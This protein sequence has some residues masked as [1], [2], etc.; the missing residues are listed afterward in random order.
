MVTIEERFREKFAASEDWHRRGRELFAGGITHQT[1]FTSPFA[2]YIEHGDGPFKFDVDGNELVDYV[3]GNGSLLMGH[4][5]SAVTD[6]V[7]AQATRGTHHGWRRLPTKSDTLRQSSVSC[8]TWRR[9][10]FT[11]SGTESTYLALRL[12]RAYTGKTKI[13][14]F[15]EHF[16]GWHDYVTPE[17]GQALGGVPRE[18]I[19]TV[20]VAPVDAAALDRILTE[21][22]DVAA[23]IVECQR[24]ALRHLPADESR[25]SS[26]HT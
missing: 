19:D 26:G 8:R 22:D 13:V 24:R 12:A 20:I 25:L 16:H 18:I 23:V 4:N 6:A 9:V 15:H 14:K 17:S 10:R 5:P 3:M 21:N 2:V 1:R 11:A 7:A